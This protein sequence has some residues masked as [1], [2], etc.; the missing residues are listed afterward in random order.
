MATILMY[1]ER[2]QLLRAEVRAACLHPTAP[3]LRRKQ[4]LGCHTIVLAA[5][6]VF[7]TCTLAL[8]LRLF[9]ASSSVRAPAPWRPPPHAVRLI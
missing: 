3:H 9:A 5:E 2:F 6:A 4:H 7:V 8:A 1:G